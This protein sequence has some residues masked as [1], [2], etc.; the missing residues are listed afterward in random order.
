M[1]H[2]SVCVYVNRWDHT[3]MQIEV[4][5]KQMW[6][7]AKALNAYNMNQ[8]GYKKWKLKFLSKETYVNL[9]SV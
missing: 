2:M 5:R 4:E 7:I 1:L 3:Y 9:K 6:K 8:Y